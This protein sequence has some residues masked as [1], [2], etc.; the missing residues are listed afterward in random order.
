MDQSDKGDT[1]EGSPYRASAAGEAGGSQDH[2]CNGAQFRPVSSNRY[3][4][5]DARGESYAAESREQ[6]HDP[7]CS[8]LQ[9]RYVDPGKPR[10][11]RVVTDIVI[12][13]KPSRSREQILE[14]Q[15][16]A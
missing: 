5:S 8:N 13:P 15:G 10:G 14:D 6:P 12:L 16:N 1:H 7:E 2:C 3:A 9:P 4:G 11:G